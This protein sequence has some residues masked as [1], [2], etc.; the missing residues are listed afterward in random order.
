MEM[1][2]VYSAAIERNAIRAQQRQPPASAPASPFTYRAEHKDTVSRFMQRFQQAWTM[3]E[4]SKL[5]RLSV[6]VVNH[7]LYVL[8]S[9]DMVAREYPTMRGRRGNPQRYRWITR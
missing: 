4:L 8:I 2:I 1:E 5:L 3:T 6:H 7:A 9:E